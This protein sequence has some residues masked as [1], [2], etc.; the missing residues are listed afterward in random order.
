MYGYWEDPI[1]PS[2]Q[3]RNRP[4]YKRLLDKHTQTTWESEKAERRFFRVVVYNG[5]LRITNIKI[6]PYIKLSYS[7][8]EKKTNPKSGREPFWNESFLFEEMQPFLTV[9]LFDKNKIGHDTYLGS[10]SVDLSELFLSQE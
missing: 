7:L 5:V 2:K 4:V 6:D 10:A 8:L 3:S 1:F 9:K